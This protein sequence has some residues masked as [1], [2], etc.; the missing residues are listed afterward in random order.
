M[1]YKILECSAEEWAEQS[2][3]MYDNPISLNQYLSANLFSSL[4]ILPEQ[5]ELIRS[6][7]FKLNSTTDLISTA[8]MCAYYISPDVIRIRGLYVLPA[9]RNKGLMSYLMSEVLKKYENHAKKII[10]FSYEKSIPF[11]IKNGFK[12]EHGFVPRSNILYDIKR[13]RYFY[14]EKGKL[15]LM[16]KEMGS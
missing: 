2:M 13:G 14:D 10:S 6:R 1:S 12:I 16:S 7:Y 3:K 5:K 15:Y 11:H 9:F 8:W 4:Q